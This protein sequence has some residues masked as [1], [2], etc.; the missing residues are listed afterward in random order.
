VVIE[1]PSAGRHR[2]P[3]GLEV[4]SRIDRSYGDTAVSVLRLE[5]R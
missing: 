2:E 1:H 5:G 4:A 3:S